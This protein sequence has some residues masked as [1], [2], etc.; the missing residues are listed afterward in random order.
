MK[1]VLPSK[2]T[3]MPL[4]E[5]TPGLEMMRCVTHIEK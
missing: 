4:P 5:A 1:A 2:L 3:E